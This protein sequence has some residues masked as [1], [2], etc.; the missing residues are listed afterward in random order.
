MVKNVSVKLLTYR[1]SVLTIEKHIKRDLKYKN[2]TSLLAH[3][4]NLFSAHDVKVVFITVV[5]QYAPILLASPVIS[6]HPLS[7]D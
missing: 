2:K 4:S 3:Y 6:E 7:I 1:V 5:F